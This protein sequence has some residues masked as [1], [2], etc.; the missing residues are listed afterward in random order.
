MF[1]QEFSVAATGGS[2]TLNGVA[3][4]G[5]FDNNSATVLNILGGSNPIFECPEANLNG[6]DPR[7][8]PMVINT[9]TYIVREN[10]PDG[11]GWT[12]LELDKQ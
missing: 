2:A 4:D 3:I 11:N 12:I 8:L 9:V 6:A 7:G 5:I 1:L 10:K